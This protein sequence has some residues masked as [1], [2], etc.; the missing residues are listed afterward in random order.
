MEHRVSST[1][2]AVDHVHVAA[3]VERASSTEQIVPAAR[4]VECCSSE[5]EIR[6]DAGVAQLRCPTTE[7]LPS[8]RDVAD[9]EAG[10]DVVRGCEYSAT[11][12]PHSGIGAERLDKLA[13]PIWRDLTVIVRKCQDSGAARRDTDISRMR[14]AELGVAHNA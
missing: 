8:L 13:Q 6:G 3:A 7:P 9:D 5:S 10:R 11:G 2:D 12:H 1:E 14:R 4:R